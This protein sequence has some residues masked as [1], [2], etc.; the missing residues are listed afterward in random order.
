MAVE[1]PTKTIILT[2]HIGCKAG[3]MVEQQ[4]PRVFLK[5]KLWATGLTT[6]QLPSFG[7]EVSAPLPL[8]AEI[9]LVKELTVPSLSITKIEFLPG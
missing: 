2:N 6:L 9:K 3:L 1:T 5:R 8:V 4:G 7:R